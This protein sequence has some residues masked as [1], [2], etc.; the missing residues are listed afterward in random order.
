MANE[1]KTILKSI[2]GPVAP[3]KVPVDV[4]DL[5]GNEL[6]INFTGIPRARDEWMPI[7]QKIMN[8]RLEKAKKAMEDA[9]IDD[10][11]LKLETKEQIAAQRK[12]RVK[13][14][15][16]MQKRDLAKEYKGSV[17][18]Q[19]EEVLQVAQGWELDDEFN[20]VNLTNVEGRFPGCLRELVEK[21]GRVVNGERVKNS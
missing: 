12:K 1:A 19:I 11:E 7:G 2:S 17:A 18:E 8:D 14:L 21:Y 15:T 6:V 9:P 5:N 16:E 13:E 20:K 4:I 10:P 3:F